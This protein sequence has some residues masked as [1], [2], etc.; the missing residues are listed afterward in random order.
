MD[1]HRTHRTHRT[2]GHTRAHTGTHGH[3]RAH[4]GTHRHTQAHTG[5][6]KGY[7]QG[8][9]ASMA[10]LAGMAG[11]PG[12]G[13]VSAGLDAGLDTGLDAGLEP[14]GSAADMFSLMLHDRLLALERDVAKL[15][16][17]AP[18]PAITLIGSATSAD[19]GAVFVRARC[20]AA[21]NV[22]RWCESMMREVARVDPARLDAWCC[23]HWSMAHSRG[24]GVYIVEALLE[25]WYTP[26]G[27]SV[28]DVAHA[29]LDALRGEGHED[30]R[31][32]ACAVTNPRWFAE[33]IRSACEASSEG[34]VL[35]TWDPESDGM[36][37]S[38]CSSEAGS[39]TLA[40][41]KAW[42][43]LH[44]WLAMHTERTDVWHPRSLSAHS[45]TNQLTS[46]LAKLGEA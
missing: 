4:T 26:H 3:T 20:S 11:G 7:S 18:D 2:H 10:S 42:T 27:I 44:G 40:E 38:A 16:P 31:L 23:Q 35:R 30:A 6:G 19:S 1:T 41:T 17:V 36:V 24:N 39:S 13:I 33:S 37:R 34:A 15:A 29:A 43:M 46:T 25:R 28:T 12:D 5:V 21:V 14:L 9:M 22:D 8:L 45:A 32:E